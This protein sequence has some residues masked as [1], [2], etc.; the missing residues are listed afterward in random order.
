MTPIPSIHCF[1]TTT[2]SITILLFLTIT[3]LTTTARGASLSQSQSQCYFP[4]GTESSGDVPC[5]PSAEVSMCCP[6]R[7]ACL[8][9]GLCANAGT[10]PSEGISYARGTCTDQSWRSDICPQRCRISRFCP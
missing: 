10:G 9:S 1:P 7:E 3:T 2:T 5:D 8:S 4:S 6:T